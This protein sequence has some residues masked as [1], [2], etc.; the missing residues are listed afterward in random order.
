MI[1][2]IMLQESRNI[3]I[4]KK[5]CDINDI[6]LLIGDKIIPFNNISG[7]D[8]IPFN[9]IPQFDEDITNT[10]IRYK[11]INCILNKFAISPNFDKIQEL[12]KSIRENISTHKLN[13]II[14]NEINNYLLDYDGKNNSNEG[15]IE[16]AY[17]NLD[18]WG[19]HFLLSLMIGY[20]T[21]LRINFKNPG[22][23]HF[24]G[25]LY[26]SIFDFILD[27]TYFDTN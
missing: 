17:K 10:I 5:E 9:N 6:S 12:Y 24:G 23:Q 18:T 27:L 3:L 11:I 20:K 4:S 25:S 21:E 26:N 7:T 2:S 16:I 19:K 22:V 8:I 15:Q 14:K 13:D 1:G